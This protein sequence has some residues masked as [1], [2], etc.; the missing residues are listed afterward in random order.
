MFR[1]QKYAFLII[2]ATESSSFI[3]MVTIYSPSKKKKRLEF[4]AGH[5]FQNILGTTFRITSDPDF[6]REQTM[7]CINYSGEVLHHGLQIIP[8]GLLFDTGARS[9]RNFQAAEWNGLFCFF[10]SGKGDFP[11]DIFAAAFYLLSLYGE[12]LPTCLDE[13]GR[14]DHQYSF[15][16][17]HN[18]LETPIIDRWAYRLKDALEKTG[19]PAS[20]FPLRSYRAIDTYDVD[21]PFLY[22][23]KGFAK[24][25][26]RL[27]KSLLKKNFTAVRKRLSVLLRRE[28]DPYMKALRFIHATETQ[29]GRSYHLFVLL[30][31]RGKY[32]R[33]I[34]YPPKVYYRYLQDLTNVIIGLHPSY[35]KY[36]VRSSHPSYTTL[37]N[38]KQTLEKI[39]HQP[40]VCSRQHFLQMQTPFTFRSLIRVGI[41]EDFTLAFAKAPGFR[42]GT[43]VPHHFYDLL[44]EEKTE[45]LL[46]PTVMMD[47]TLIVHLRLSPED[48]LKKIKSLIDACRQSGGDYLSLWHNSNLAGSPDENPWI[49]VFVE[50]HH[51]ATASR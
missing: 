26:G 28:E 51:Y 22:R 31:R 21:H 16:F 24:N 4:V 40:V 42:S 35:R 5:L 39:I 2:F 27:L 20:E 33:S 6:Y 41:R 8:H 13:H 3:Q 14:F 36:K 15:L 46:H 49:R 48:A 1:S 23:Y 12:Y 11:F 44:R 7:P 43:A 30:G 9:I 10:H 47:S 32:G 19:L 45:L 18:L 50:S 25:A 38:E 34:L 29:A 17:Q 37:I